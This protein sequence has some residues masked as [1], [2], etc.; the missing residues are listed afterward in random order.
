MLI[1]TGDAAQYRRIPI[2]LDAL[3][4]EARSSPSRRH[5]SSPDFTF[6]YQAPLSGTGAI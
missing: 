3:I 2:A 1:Q 6:C 5:E 4:Q